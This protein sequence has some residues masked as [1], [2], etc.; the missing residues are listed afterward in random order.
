MK[1]KLEAKRAACV[2][3]IAV[4]EAALERKKGRLEFINELIAEEAEEAE[5][6]YANFPAE[7]VEAEDTDGDT[8]GSGETVEYNGT[9]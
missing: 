1:E 5:A 4:L 9:L 8:D 3:E 6:N 2:D 7:G